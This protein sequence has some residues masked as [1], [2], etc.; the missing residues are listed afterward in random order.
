[1]DTAPPPPNAVASV[2]FVPDSNGFHGAIAFM[3]L[4]QGAP[5]DMAQL[6]QHMLETIVMRKG[7]ASLQGAF[8]E[9][10]FEYLARQSLDV[11]I[12]FY[13]HLTTV[14]EENYLQ[15]IDID[16]NL[17]YLGALLVFIEQFIQVRA[18]VVRRDE[19]SVA[20]P[21]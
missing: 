6:L 2:E 16:G 18:P 12:H 4:Y 3:V 10:N 8:Y 1:M 13:Y 5:A 9:A 14:D 7:Q 21:E 17:I 20:P 19:A 11:P 15:V